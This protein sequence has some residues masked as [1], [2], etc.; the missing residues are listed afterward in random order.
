[1]RDDSYAFHSNSEKRDFS[2]WVRGVIK[3]VD[4]AIDLARSTSR[5][6]AAKKTA[7]RVASLSDMLPG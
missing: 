5:L 2:N 6:E 7:Y 4:L 3:D 1:M